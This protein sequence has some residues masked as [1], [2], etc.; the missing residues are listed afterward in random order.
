MRRTIT[1]ALLAGLLAGATATG[2]LVVPGA[3]AAP[4]VDLQ[5]QALTRG[6]DIAVPHIEDGV[7]VDGDRRTELPGND[8]RVVGASGDAWLVA[9][10]TTNRV[11]EQRRARVVRVEPDGEV[12]TILVGD[13]SRSA[14]VSEEGSR[15]VVVEETGRRRAAVVVRFAEDGGEVARRVM[16]GWPQAVTADDRKVVVQTMRRTVTWRVG[17]DRVRTITRGIAGLADIEHDLFAT[18]TKDPYLGGCMRLVRLSDLTET[19]WRS[20]KERVAAISPDGTQMLTFHILTDGVGPGEITLR[21][22]RGKRLATWTTGWFSG[23]QWESP[24]TVLLEV[25]GRRKASTVRCTLAQC[26]NATDPVKVTPP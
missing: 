3:A 23:W 26:E 16:D 22:I 2:A 8:A 25:N 13:E 7:L 9:A 19:V 21:T 4:T 14:L 1:H 17:P 24:G 10:W 11:G 20:C 6:A 5:P 12:R 15:L 18:Y